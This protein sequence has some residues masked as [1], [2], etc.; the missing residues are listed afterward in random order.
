MKIQVQ[1]NATK[2]SR[3]KNYVFTANNIF[4]FISCCIKAKRMKAS[5]IFFH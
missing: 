1:I 5:A 2:D 3:E 4:Q